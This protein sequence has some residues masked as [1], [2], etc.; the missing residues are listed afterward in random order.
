MTAINEIEKK[1][2]I[3]N[4]YGH[5]Y[6]YDDHFYQKPIWFISKHENRKKKLESRVL[7]FQFFGLFFFHCRL[8]MMTK[9]N[10]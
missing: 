2:Q 4:D 5:P 8:K 10:G 7:F 6:G 9:I 3:N 1:K